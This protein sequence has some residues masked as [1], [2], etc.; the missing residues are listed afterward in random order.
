MSNLEKYAP[1][2]VH[3]LGDFIDFLNDNSDDGTEPRLGF[4]IEFMERNQFDSAL[5]LP[6]FKHRANDIWS[7]LRGGDLMSEKIADREELTEFQIKNVAFQ[8][9]NHFR[10]KFGLTAVLGDQIDLWELNPVPRKNDELI[11]AFPDL[12]KRK[13]GEASR[14]EVYEVANCL[15]HQY[16]I[17]SDYMYEVF[18]NA[19]NQGY[20][21]KNNS[22]DKEVG[23]TP[24]AHLYIRDCRVG[25]KQD[26]TF[27]SYEDIIS[28][29]LN[30]Y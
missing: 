8:L 13:S 2:S 27:M 21:R 16:R 11:V 17:I 15:F 14:E 24:L 1:L 12:C 28:S 4:E 29:L 23:R 6:F 18:S 19:E 7:P 10:K 26:F 9:K 22:Y 25:L 3:E 5:L 20:Y 30:H